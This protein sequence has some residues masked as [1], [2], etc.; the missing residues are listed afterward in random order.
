M[1][2]LGATQEE[3]KTDVGQLK[4]QMTRILEV[5]TALE[6]RV[7]KSEERSVQAAK[8][9][10]VEFPPFG[11]PPGYTPPT[12][13]YAEQNQIPLVVP[14]SMPVTHTSKPEGLQTMLDDNMVSG[15]MIGASTSEGQQVTAIP[16]VLQVLTGDGSQSKATTVGIEGA[17]GKLECLEE[18]LRVIE[19]WSSYGLGEAAELCLVPDVVIPSKF[20]VPE[21]EKYKGTTCP[22]NHLTMYCRKMSAHAHNEKLLIHFF[23]DSLAGMA[24]SWYMHLEPTHIHSWKDLVSAFLKQYKYNIDMAPDR[25][26]LQSMTKKGV[27]TFKEYAQ[28]WREVAA[29]VEP[30]LHEK[31]MVAMFIDTLQSPFYEHMVGS[32]IGRAHV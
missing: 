8:A 26:Q 32:E 1:D 3:I 19:G 10:P 23:Q 31:E 20:K 30:P 5:L 17:K 29:Q 13:E 25:M 18:R 15:N 12:Q 28:R 24:L 21:F 11:L 7:S 2:D 4:D 6:S 27:E 22:K 14:I 9:T 16:K